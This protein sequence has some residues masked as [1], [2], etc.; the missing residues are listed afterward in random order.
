MKN[1]KNFLKREKDER[2]KIV[3]LFKN[4]RIG[5]L[6]RKYLSFSISLPFPIKIKDILENIFFE[7]EELARQAVFSD[8]D[9]PK[10]GLFEIFINDNNEPIDYFV[11][12]FVYY[13]D[14]KNIE[15]KRKQ[16]SKNFVINEFNHDKIQKIC[17]LLNFTLTDE[18]L[19]GFD[20]DYLGK[21]L[22]KQN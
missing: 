12:A 6:N 3:A 1:L 17:I 5:F 8:C 15:G 9:D 16:V 21:I 20:E 4:V 11:K 13:N 22:I 18:I 7:D 2:T 19:A 14:D 10:D